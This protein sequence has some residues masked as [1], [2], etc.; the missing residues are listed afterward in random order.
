MPLA[1]VAQRSV[2]GFEHPD[3]LGLI[4]SMVRNLDGDGLVFPRDSPP[5]QR[6]GLAEHERPIELECRHQF[7]GKRWCLLNQLVPQARDA[8]GNRGWVGMEDLVLLPASPNPA[9]ELQFRY[10][11]VVGAVPGPRHQDKLTSAGRVLPRRSSG[12]VGEYG[13][14]ARLHGTVAVESAVP[15]TDQF[16]GISHGGQCAT[17]DN[18]Q[19][20]RKLSR[21]D[22]RRHF[23]A[24]RDPTLASQSGSVRAWQ[25][26][27]CSSP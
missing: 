27:E 6:V 19:A 7:G 23:R 16:I 25:P 3:C 14:R 13:K 26:E 5:A 20:H 10:R 15:E 18:G 8:C 4:A 11:E 17:T 22:Q 12:S 24:E 21:A 1:G 2:G 9:N